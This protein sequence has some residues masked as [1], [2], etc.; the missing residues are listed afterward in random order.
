[1]GD[2]VCLNIYTYARGVMSSPPGSTTDSTYQ[3]YLEELASS[4]EKPIFITQ[5]G[6]STS[7][8]ESKPATA[9]GF[10]GHKEKDVPS[11][12]KSIWKDLHTAKG[13]EKFCGISFF[14]L[15]DEWWKSGEDPVDSTRHEQDD[16]EEWFGLFQVGPD[17][18]LIPKKNI[19]NTLRE[20]YTS[21]PNTL[22]PKR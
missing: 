11:V 10:G 5:V 6:L 8:I 1:M 15:Q 18:H 7:N 3:G 4:T 14:E 12:F 13:K 22:T 20:L 17:R 2:L 9:P 19:P 16:P 21:S